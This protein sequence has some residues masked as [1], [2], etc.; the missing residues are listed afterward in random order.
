MD[1]NPSSSTLQGPRLLDRLR[2]TIRRRH[3]SR[4]TEEAYTHWTKRFIYF[5]GKCHPSEL[6]ESEVTAF[7]N[8][9]AMDKDVAASTQNQALSA[10][11]FLYKEALGLELAWLDG[12]VR[13]KRPDRMP[14]VL[15]RQETQA[16][17]NFLTGV[18]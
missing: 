16:V 14:V 18:H 7:L 8:H 10:L 9:L 3:Y 5:H 1:S 13:A 6:G 11:L 15:T 12:L 4:R 17:L 2:G